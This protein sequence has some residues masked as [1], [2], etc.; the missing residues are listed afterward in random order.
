MNTLLRRKK[1]NKWK[2]NLR[3]KLQLK[4]SWMQA[5]EQLAKTVKGLE[6]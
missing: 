2:Q 4:R 6:K 1:T 5:A 3:S